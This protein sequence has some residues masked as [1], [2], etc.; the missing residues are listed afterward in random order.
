MIKMN[1]K[2]MINIILYIYTYIT[3]YIR[4]KSNYIR[5]KILIINFRKAIKIF[6]LILFF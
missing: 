4:V 5:V 1:I 2:K 3:N 6:Y